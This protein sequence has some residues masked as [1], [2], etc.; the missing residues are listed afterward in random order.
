MKVMKNPG[1]W[2]FISNQKF[3]LK[4]KKYIMRTEKYQQF[5]LLL[6]FAHH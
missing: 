3:P 2:V 5:V 4:R 1:K 6:D